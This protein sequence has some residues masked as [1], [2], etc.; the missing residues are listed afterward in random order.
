MDDVVRSVGSAIAYCVAGACESLGM[1]F[2][3]FIEPWSSGHAPADVNAAVFET[4]GLIGY[5]V[6]AAATAVVVVA[7]DVLY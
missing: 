7:A 4:S 6:G 3:G 1:L 5:P 2:K